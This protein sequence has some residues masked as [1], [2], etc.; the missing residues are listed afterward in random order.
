[1]NYIADNV[2]NGILKDS[3][4][5]LK[6]SEWVS[7]PKDETMTLLYDQDEVFLEARVHYNRDLRFVVDNLDFNIWIGEK[8][9]YLTMSQKKE[10]VSFL[11]FEYDKAI[12]V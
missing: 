1:M 2:L 4:Y 6:D 5:E 7:L 9:I 12:A 3:D 10:I 8:E 11:E